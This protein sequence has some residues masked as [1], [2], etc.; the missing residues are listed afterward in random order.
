MPDL[1]AQLDAVRYA[2]WILPA[3]ALLAAAMGFIRPVRKGL[4]PRESHGCLSDAHVRLSAE[5]RQSTEASFDT[6]RRT[7]RNEKGRLRFFG[8]ASTTARIDI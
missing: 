6:D 2:L 8:H 3:A 1:H 5:S 4:R 7:T